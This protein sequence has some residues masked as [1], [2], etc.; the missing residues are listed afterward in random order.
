MR[1][2]QKIRA[3]LETLLQSSPEAHLLLTREGRVKYV[4]P[5]ALVTFASEA[6][7]MAG[8]LVDQWIPSYDL[9]SAESNEIEAEGVSAT[10]DRF[11][12]EYS[13]T[14]I[15]DDSGHVWAVV[16]DIQRRKGFE[17][18]IRMYASELENSVRARKKEIA[19]LNDRIKV[20]TAQW[21]Q[22]RAVIERL[23]ANQAKLETARTEAERAHGAPPRVRRAANPRPC[24]GVDVQRPFGEPE[25]GVRLV[26]L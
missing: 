20:M 8:S 3:W 22:E 21:Q 5:A 24:L 4:N 23:R 14:A 19:E 1:R 11:P 25:V 9:A 16:R 7:E 12:I 13:I 6:D 26:D 10:G 2:P 15:H 18:S 17:G